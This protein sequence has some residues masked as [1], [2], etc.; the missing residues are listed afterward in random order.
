MNRRV[1]ER[2]ERE[3]QRMEAERRKEQEE[4][5]ALEQVP[6]CWIK[7]HCERERRKEQEGGAGFGTGTVP[8]T[9]GV[10]SSQVPVPHHD[11]SDANYCT[12]F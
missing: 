7:E 2:S 10:T 5:R 11:Q 8:G 9:A 1:K 4:E 6:Y 3:R 12:P